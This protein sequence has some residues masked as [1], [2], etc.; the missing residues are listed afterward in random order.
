MVV[1]GVCGLQLRGSREHWGRERK[2]KGPRL[3][4]LAL[5][6]AE[7]S[8]STPSVVHQLATTAAR[9]PRASPVA[10]ADMFGGRTPYKRRRAVWTVRRLHFNIV[11]QNAL[12]A[13]SSPNSELKCAIL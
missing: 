12:H 11:L 10:S 7:G 1:I 5:E 8:S 3:R 13:H 9:L 4:G 2:N 6:I